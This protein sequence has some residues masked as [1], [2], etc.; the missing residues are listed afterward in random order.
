MVTA[1]SV[2]A[3]GFVCTI[4]QEPRSSMTTSWSE[5]WCP[6]AS[7]NR[8]RVFADSRVDFDRDAW[9]RVLRLV[10]GTL[11]L[12]TQRLS[13]RRRGG[14]KRKM[15]ADCPRRFRLVSGGKFGCAYEEPLEGIALILRAI[16]LTIAEVGARDGED[17]DEQLE[18]LSHMREVWREKAAE[19]S[20][21]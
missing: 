1:I 10:R 8:S 4:R 3:P 2:A 14:R 7:R 16:D 19:V 15:G 20:G 21:D 6:V 11:C 13:S 5:S 18:I 12:S 9:L 17:R